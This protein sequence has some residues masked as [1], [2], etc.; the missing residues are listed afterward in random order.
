MKD[1]HPS[2]RAQFE[3][4]TCPVSMASYRNER[5]GVGECLNDACKDRLMLRKEF[6]WY[7]MTATILVT[8]PHLLPSKLYLP[9]SM[10]AIKQNNNHGYH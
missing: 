5:L 6:A 3:A 8:G 1:V 2:A 4:P 7:E 10:T 9:V